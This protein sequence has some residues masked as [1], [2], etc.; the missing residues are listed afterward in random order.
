MD[1]DI[2]L[3]VRVSVQGEISNLVLN[4]NK[5]PGLFFVGGK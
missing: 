2:N 4:G 1:G 5:P 3:S